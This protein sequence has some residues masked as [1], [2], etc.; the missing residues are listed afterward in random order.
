V[1]HVRR[2]GRAG[3]LLGGGVLGAVADQSRDGILVER[4]EAAA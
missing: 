2:F 3:D 4:L 1:V